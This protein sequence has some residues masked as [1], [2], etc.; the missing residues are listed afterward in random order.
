MRACYRLGDADAITTLLRHHTAALDDI[1]A[2]PAEET[3]DLAE[4]LRRDLDRRHTPTR[5]RLT[6]TR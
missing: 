4:H 3:I 5:G 2:E 1:A 6:R